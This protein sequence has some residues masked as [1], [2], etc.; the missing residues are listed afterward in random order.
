MIDDCGMAIG[1]PVHACLNCE[2][3]E[4]RIPLLA[5][6]FRGQAVHICPQCLPT[7]IHQPE[8]LAAKLPGIDTTR[9]VETGH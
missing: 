1:G 2:C 6:Q 7:L 4:E 3:T 8:K 9:P 5:L